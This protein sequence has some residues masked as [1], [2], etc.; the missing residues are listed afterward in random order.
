MKVIKRDGTLID[1]DDNK[2]YHANEGACNSI[3]DLECIQ[4]I[5]S[6]IRNV[7]AILESGKYCSRKH[8]VKIED[9]QDVV[10]MCLMNDG[11]TDVAK[12]YIS[13]RKGTK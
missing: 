2:I 12:A 8:N 6:I 1:F 9:I 5:D 3:D 13:H 11:F 4:V 7:L 10:G